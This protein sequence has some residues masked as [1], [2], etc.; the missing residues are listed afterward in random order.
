MSHT[1]LMIRGWANISICNCIKSNLLR[2]RTQRESLLVYVL[3]SVLISF[4]WTRLWSHGRHVVDNL[5]VAIKFCGASVQILSSRL[6]MSHDD[7]RLTLQLQPTSTSHEC[8]LSGLQP[9]M[10]SV[11]QPAKIL[12]P[13]ILSVTRLYSVSYKRLQYHAEIPALMQ[14]LAT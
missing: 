7:S 2:W 9:E 14:N 1:F 4:V 13:G 11:T 3:F 5:S 12:K 10:A 8:Q 6:P